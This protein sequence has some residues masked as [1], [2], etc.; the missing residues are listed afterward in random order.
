MRLDK[1]VR[2]ANEAKTGAQKNRVGTTI[3]SCDCDS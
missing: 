2:I 3:T 1:L